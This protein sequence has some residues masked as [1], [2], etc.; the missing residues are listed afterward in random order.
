MTRHRIALS[1]LALSI[2]AGCAGTGRVANRPVRAPGQAR[3]EAVLIDGGA[4]KDR[5]YRSHLDQLRLLANLLRRAGLSARELSVFSA[6]GSAPTPD[7]ATREEG[8]FPDHWLLQGSRLGRML[9][10][11]VYADSSIQGI[12][13]LP[14]KKAA[15]ETWFHTMADELGPGDT[16]L[17]YVT[18]HGQ[19]VGRKG[20]IFISLWYERLSL[21]ELA[22]WLGELDPG[23]RV[24]M[25]MSQCYS[26]AFA[27]LMYRDPE[28][29]E[30]AG[31]TCGFFSCLP[32]DLAWGCFPEAVETK[33]LKGHS[34][35][36]LEGL[37]PG[38]TLAD[39]HRRTLLADH[40]PNVPNASSDAYL[41][42]LL[43]R[44]AKRTGQPR[45]RVADGLLAR[46][47]SRPGC[48]QWQKDVLD[49]LGR[50]LG[51]E[52]P[53][54]SLLD[55]AGLEKEIRAGRQQAGRLRS[56]WARTLRSLAKATVGRFQEQAADWQGRTI[57][58]LFAAQGLKY[59]NSTQAEQQRQE[60][61]ERAVAEVAAFVEQ[62]PGLRERLERLRHKAEGASAVNLRMARREATLERMRVVLEALAGSV[63][64]DED[65]DRRSARQALL[66]CE[67]WR[68]PG[69]P[70]EEPDPPGAGPALPPMAGDLA[71]LEQLR[72]AWLGVRYGPEDPALIAEHHLG[73]GAVVV[74]S[75]V[76]GSPAEVAGLQPGDTI[77]GLKA[78][79]FE[80][81]GSLSE[82]VMQHPI[83]QAMTLD[84][85]RDGE[86]LALS[87]ELA[88][89]PD[90]VPERPA[91][92]EVGAVAPGFRGLRSFRGTAPKSSPMLLFFFAT[93]CGP[94]K[95]AA[96]ALIDWE[97]EHNI[98]VVAVTHEDED[99]VKAFFGSY[100]KPFPERIAI[101]PRGLIT[102]AFRATAFPTFVLVGADG[103]VKAYGRGSKAL[104]SD[105]FSDPD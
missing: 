11:L 55:L 94:C 59:T 13:L 49:T 19:R 7:L 85:L 10:D 56:R 16:L 71:A 75:V 18:D 103:K 80:D 57:R 86:H 91:K 24:V 39:A 41:R 84:V 51:V 29:L 52:K 5:N 83:G 20:E 54:R 14:A 102:D 36:M 47:W 45:D 76:P 58:E 3:V 6:D 53:V 89:F 95:H 101:D 50:R 68:L 69:G 64:A 66:K 62:E 35:R 44:E 8:R 92:L 90:K 26:G 60:M 21:S 48:C 15:L 4:R 33:E 23:V 79:P 104:E 38:G 46:A 77:V 12:R 37:S 82:N 43:T 61:T 105:A 98:P 72:P 27:R 65:E 32:D 96:P 67:A 34:F 40:T 9:P 88:A 28:E 17:L 63:L 81:T 30:V 93:W 100:D 42:D 74:R 31:N 22:A 25:W 73:T 87:A 2:L 99:V 97:K 1:S 70:A 78:Q